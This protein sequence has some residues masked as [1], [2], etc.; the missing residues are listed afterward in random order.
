MTGVKSSH[1]KGPMADAL[2]SG[3]KAEAELD[4]ALGIMY[5]R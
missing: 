2:S 5:L 4:K 1:I 3:S